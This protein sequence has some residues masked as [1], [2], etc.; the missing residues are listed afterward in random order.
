[1]IHFLFKGLYHLHKVTVKVLS[2]SS[3]VFGYSG[4]AF[5]EAI[6][7]IILFFWLMLALL[8][9]MGFALPTGSNV[10]DVRKVVDPYCHISLHLLMS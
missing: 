9:L 8:L 7:H 3:S 10:I 5:V 1:I 6:Q 2:S 4:L